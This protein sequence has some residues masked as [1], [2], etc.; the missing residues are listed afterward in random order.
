[1]R[2]SRGVVAG[3]FDGDGDLDLYIVNF[4]AKNELYFNDGAG[5][6]TAASEENNDAVS[7]ETFGTGALSTVGSVGVVTA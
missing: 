4:D 7:L 3:D 1:M 6:F 5:Q 2:D